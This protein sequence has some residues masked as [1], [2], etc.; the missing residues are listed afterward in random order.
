MNINPFYY[1]LGAAFTALFFAL[2]RYAHFLYYRKVNKN[3]PIKY[4]LLSTYSDY[5]VFGT[6]TESRRQFMRSN[7]KLQTCFWVCLILAFAFFGIILTINN[8]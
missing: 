7:N 4:K 2:A 3:R 5:E 8:F 6:A 1:G